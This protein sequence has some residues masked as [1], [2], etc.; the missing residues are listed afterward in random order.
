MISKNK[1]E[2]PLSL[3][4]IHIQEILGLGRRKTYE[5]LNDKPPFHMVKVGKLI[6]VSRES[7]FVWFEGK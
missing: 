5:F 7:F 3:E 1:E 6:K 4:P 2:Y